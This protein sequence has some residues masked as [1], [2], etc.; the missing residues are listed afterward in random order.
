MFCLI[1][2]ATSPAHRNLI[3]ITKVTTTSDLDKL[4]SSLCNVLHYQLT[5]NY[6]HT[7]NKF[8]WAYFTKVYCL[9]TGRSQHFNIC[10]SGLWNL[11]YIHITIPTTNPRMHPSA[12]L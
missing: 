11:C 9:N 1:S 10:F 6:T 5:F 3:D 12:W 2:L 4:S 8:G 7:W